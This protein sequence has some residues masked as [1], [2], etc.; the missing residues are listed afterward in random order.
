[1]HYEG[2]V[3]MWQGANRIQAETIDLDRE[4]RDLV[5]DGNVVIA[6]CGSSPKGRTARRRTAAVPVLTVVHAPHLVY[7]E[8][9]RLAVYS[10]GVML[11]RPESASEVAASMHAFLADSG[12][13]S[14]LEKA[15]ADGAVEIVPEVAARRITYTA[16][17]STANTIRPNRR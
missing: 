11:E 8:E 1:M 9:N 13:D 14:R 2:N 16:P 12:A 15:F 10:G 6:T 3:M 4:K 7:T 5:A 17:P